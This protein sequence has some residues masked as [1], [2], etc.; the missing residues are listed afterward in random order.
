M[1]QFLNH[2]LD[3]KIFATVKVDSDLDTICWENRADLA[4][5]FLYYR[6]FK[7][8][9]SLQEQFLKWGYEQVPQSHITANDFPIGVK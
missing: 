3:K 8:D 6:C 2:Y 9:V 5:E 1:E 7:D 4:P